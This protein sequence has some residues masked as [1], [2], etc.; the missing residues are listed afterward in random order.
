[1]FL[2]SSFTAWDIVSPPRWIGVHNYVMI[3]TDDDDFVQALKV[4]LTYAAFGLPLQLVLGL[5]LSLLLNL[6]LHAM[7]LYRTLFYIPAVLPAVA[8]T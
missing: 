4:T 3:F 8:V 1:M 7:N 2:S 6:R 5:A